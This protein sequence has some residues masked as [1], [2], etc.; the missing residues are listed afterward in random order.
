[1]PSLQAGRG[2][3]DCDLRQ[4]QAWTAWSAHPVG[5]NA[6]LRATSPPRDLEEELPQHLGKQGCQVLVPEGSQTAA[7]ANTSL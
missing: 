5:S 7:Y 3:A 6:W 2:F 4:Q 1:M